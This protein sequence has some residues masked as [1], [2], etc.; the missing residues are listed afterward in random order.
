LHRLIFCT[1]ACIGI[2]GVA[3][4]HAAEHLPD[5]SSLLPTQDIR[6]FQVSF[7]TDFSIFKQ[8]AKDGFVASTTRVS[9]Q[10]L[11]L[12]YADDDKNNILVEFSYQNL[13]SEDDTAP[14]GFTQ[15]GQSKL[16]S[17]SFR[18]FS[19][20]DL[21]GW[22]VKPSVLLS[23]DSIRA[24]R[25]DVLSLATAFSKTSGLRTIADIEIYKNFP[26]SENL[27]LSPTGKLEHTYTFVKAYQETGAGLANLQVGDVNDQRLRSQLGAT[28]I[29]LFPTAEGG[30][31]APFLTMKWLHNFVT[32][33]LKAR[34]GQ[35]IGGGSQNVG[36]L[37]GPDAN[38]ALLN[39]GVFVKA[40]GNLEL[41]LAYEGELF[42]SSTL[43][44][45]SAY[46][47]ITF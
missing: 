22:T 35:A 6:G 21:L 33:P 44:T 3:Q 26:V 2:L 13:R 9:E 40:S 28:A 12:K 24:Q 8:R 15:G 16:R 42:K 20:F 41:I 46:M 29:G 31:V 19:E 32:A 5:F 23:S 30:L 1:V 10:T 7:E 47:K 37:A 34:T 18:A 39:T 11:G 25:R 14:A 38:G 4:G 17:Y 36:L 27:I 45:V 43:H